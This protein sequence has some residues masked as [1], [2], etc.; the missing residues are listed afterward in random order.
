MSARP[1]RPSVAAFG[2]GFVAIALSRDSENARMVRDG[3]RSRCACPPPVDRLPSFF[4]RS[5]CNATG[6]SSVT[7][8]VTEGCPGRDAGGRLFPLHFC[9]SKWEGVARR[10]LR[11]GFC[12]CVVTRKD[13]RAEWAAP[14]PC[15]PLCGREPPAPPRLVLGYLPRERRGG[16]SPLGEG[17]Q[18]PRRAVPMGTSWPDRD[19]DMASQSSTAPPWPERRL[20]AQ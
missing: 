14:F 15:C 11:T 9:P 1:H 6:P 12:R 8:T 17:T 16:G 4:V 13:R 19:A 3:G 18:T 20:V 7:T 2:R 10:R 5:C